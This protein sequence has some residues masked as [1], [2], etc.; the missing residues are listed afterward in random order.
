MVG[1]AKVIAS[2]VNKGVDYKLKTNKDFIFD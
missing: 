1:R 2:L